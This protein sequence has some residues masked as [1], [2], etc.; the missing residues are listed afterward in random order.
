MYVKIHESHVWKHR[1]KVE[2]QG[3]H[4]VN[5]RAYTDRSHD[6]NGHWKNPADI[7]VR[8]R[9]IAIAI[10]VKNSFF[11]TVTDAFFAFSVRGENGSSITGKGKRIRMY[12][13]F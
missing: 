1:K 13:I 7:T 11:F 3:D 4:F 2:T 12:Q 10:T 6:T 5:P 8:L 9:I